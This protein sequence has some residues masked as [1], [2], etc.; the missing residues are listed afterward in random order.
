VKGYN[1]KPSA[2]AGDMT[3]EKWKGLTA[4]SPEAKEFSTNELATFI[5][6]KKDDSITEIFVSGANG[7]KVAFLVKT[8]A[9]SHLGRAKHDEPMA[10]KTW[11]SDLVEKDES[12]GKQQVQV[13]FPVL[14]GDK[15]IGSI[16]VGLDVAKL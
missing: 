16:V 8:A 10:G 14:D 12:T 6:G 5:K 9:W 2:V 13:S 11:I 3:T 1:S 4:D 7:G 15:A